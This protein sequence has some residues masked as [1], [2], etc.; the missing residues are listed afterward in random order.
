M[1]SCQTSRK[2]SDILVTK[3]DYAKKDREGDTERRRDGIAKMRRDLCDLKVSQRNGERSTTGTMI[4]LSVVA[5]LKTNR[6]TVL[7]GMSV[8]KSLL[9]RPKR[10]AFS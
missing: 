2:D 8:N 6:F 3:L 9:D 5:L 7:A 4:Y 10:A 1:Y